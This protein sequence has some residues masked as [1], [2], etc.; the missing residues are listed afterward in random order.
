MTSP[1]APSAASGAGEPIADIFAD[2]DSSIPRYEPG[3]PTPD[4]ASPLGEPDDAGV[5]C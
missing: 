1:T 3:D 5:D 2:V 4:P